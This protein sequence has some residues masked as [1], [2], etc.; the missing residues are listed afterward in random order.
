MALKLRMALAGPCGLTKQSSMNRLLSFTAT[1][2][3]TCLAAGPG[4]AADT[5]RI[6]QPTSAAVSNI[7]LK[8]VSV[9]YRH[10]EGTFLKSPR[11]VW[12]DPVKSEVYVADTLNDLVAVYDSAGLPLFVFGYNKELK[13]PTKAIPDSKGRILVLNGI[14][15]AIKVFNY[16]GEYINDFPLVRKDPKSTPVAMAVDKGG[17]IYVAVASESASLIQVYDSGFQLI[18]EFGSKPDGTSYFKGVQ[19][20][21]FDGDGLIYVSDANATPSIQVYS[22]DGKF[23]RG[24]GT[25]DAG[26]QNFSLPA[27]LAIDGEGRVIVL[28]G[29]RQVI[30]IFTKE[31]ILL[32]REGGMGTQP[33]SVMYPTD[34]ATNGKGKIYL[35]ERLGSRLQ[36]LEERL[37]ATRAAPDTSAA[38]NALREQMRRQFKDI[39]R[40]MQ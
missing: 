27:G 3:L 11:G 10:V 20:I 18:R 33:G 5:T 15:K 4:Q 16:R 1:F 22:A 2:L 38:S 13:E 23:L 21:A 24:W 19:A 30:M 37:V 9:I 14:P 35:V 8:P 29:I 28:D 39:S 31:G 17:N 36:V 7:T 26:P 34:I 12:V 25:H 32:N 40:G 6:A